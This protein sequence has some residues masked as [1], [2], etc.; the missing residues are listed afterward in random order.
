LLQLLDRLVPGR[1]R[2]QALTLSGGE[3]L[4]R[5]DLEELVAAIRVALPRT[6]VNVA[7]SGVLLD[8]HRSRALHAAGVQA[9]QLTLLAPDPALHDELTGHPGSF[10][11]TLRAIAAARA[12]GLQVAVF[13]VAMRSNIETYPGVARLALA[14]GADTVVL[15]RFQ[16]GGRGLEGWR[17]RTPTPAQLQA[18]LAARAELAGPV[19]LPLG[20][21][22]PPCE[23]RDERESMVCPIGTRN[24]YP[25][26]GPDG[27]V[28]PCN[29]S[30]H[31]LGSLLEE[32]LLDLLRRQPEPA[33][34]PECA[35]CASRRRCRGGC[36]AA[37]EL[38]GEPIYAGGLHHVT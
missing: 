24:A 38:T 12:A 19:D 17:E 27:T 37:R 2:L 3:P 35:G 4:L 23:R 10:D 14:V 26:I 36:P 29:H 30:P 16:P 34:P 18:A 8:E 11:A 7:T 22:I 6:K 21:V 15:N 25:A 32:P 5:E 33:A 31:V 20:T 9:V 28:R 1:R 13:C